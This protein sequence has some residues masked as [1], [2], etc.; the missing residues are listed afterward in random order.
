MVVVAPLLESE[1]PIL[2]ALL[3]LYQY[4][5]SE[6]EGGVAGADGRYHY[7]D[8]ARFAHEYLFRVGGEP[9]GFALVNRR[10]SAVSPSEQVWSMAEFFVMRR[11]RRSGLGRDAARLV[12]ERHPGRWEIAETPH[13]EAA[14][15]FWRRILA[16]Y[17]YEEVVHADPKWGN[18]PLQRLDSPGLSSPKR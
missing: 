18:R 3:Q 1:R 16:P 6:I 4:D 17:G 11:H 9:A 2:E 14:T 7:M 12:I 13:N 10:P 15:A 5:F 8:G